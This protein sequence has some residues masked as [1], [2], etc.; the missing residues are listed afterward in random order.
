MVLLLGCSGI[1]SF[2]GE[3][4]KVQAQMDSGLI[5]QEDEEEAVRELDLMATRFGG[6]YYDRETDVCCSERLFQRGKRTAES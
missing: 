5:H 1:T 3:G 2:D 4:E 6:Y